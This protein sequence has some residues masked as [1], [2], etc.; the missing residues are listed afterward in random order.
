VTTGS[1]DLEA[2]HMD[3]MTTKFGVHSA[4]FSPDISIGSLAPDGSGFTEMQESTD[5]IL[6]AVAQFI[7]R[8]HGDGLTVE[9]PGL[10]FVLEAKVRPLAAASQERVA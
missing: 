1:D 4:Y 10:G 2:A 8:H 6:A 5:M 9:F 7:E 3:T